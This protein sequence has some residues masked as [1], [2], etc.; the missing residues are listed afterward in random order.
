MRPGK[1]PLADS[2]KPLPGDST[3]VNFSQPLPQQYNTGQDN[4][5]IKLCGANE[6]QRR[7]RPNERL[8]SHVVYSM[9]D[10]MHE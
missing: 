8:V 3:A 10:Y 1:L 9:A 7:L 2:M 4:L 6:A 5:T